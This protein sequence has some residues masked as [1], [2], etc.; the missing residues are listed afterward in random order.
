[1]PNPID[2]A[3]DA[4]LHALGANPDAPTALTALDRCED[5][6]WTG[7]V[8]EDEARAVYGGGAP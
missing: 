7:P 8:D 6:G 2:A 5:Q 1:M 4:A 3:W